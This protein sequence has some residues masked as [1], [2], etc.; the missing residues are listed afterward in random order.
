MQKGPIAADVG[1]TCSTEELA[2]ERPGHET[3]GVA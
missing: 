2:D 1:D 3:N